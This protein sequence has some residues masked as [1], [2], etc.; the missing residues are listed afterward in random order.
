M[1]QFKTFIVSKSINFIEGWNSV[2][3]SHIQQ[4]VMAEQN[5]MYEHYYK[6]PTMDERI[7]DKERMESFYYARMLST[8][9]LLMAAIAIF[10]A[11]VSLVFSVIALFHHG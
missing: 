5:K 2:I 11:F 4:K 9:N 1:S 3:H 10:V 8:A 7:K 6:P